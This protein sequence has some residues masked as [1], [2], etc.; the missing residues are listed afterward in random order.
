[1]A[2]YQPDV[3]VCSDGHQL[4]TLAFDRLTWAA[5][6]LD[7]IGLFAGNDVPGV[8]GPRALYRLL[9]R[10]G[11][12][13]RDRRIV[14]TGSGLDLWLAAAVAHARGAR[15]SVVI[16]EGGWPTEVSAAIDLGWQ[17]HSGLELDHARYDRRGTRLAFKPAQT[18]TPEPE[19]RVELGCD[20]AVVCGRG[21]PVYD[22]L[23]QLGAE[24]EHRSERG[25][26]V[27]AGTRR[28][29]FSGKLAGGQ[30]LEVGGEAAG[31]PP[32]ELLG[33]GSEAKAE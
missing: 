1:V 11:L 25:G 28:G 8:I 23:Y 21:K 29:R 14:A 5:G 19:A 6:A 20:L 2:A 18:R 12:D 3:L 9:G 32:A 10:D 4:A 7:A 17:F 30:Q 15:V 24:L 16:T 26:Y 27:P 13:V 33:S 31:M 22:I